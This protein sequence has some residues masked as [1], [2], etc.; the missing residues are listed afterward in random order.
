MSD[1][2]SYTCGQEAMRAE[3]KTEEHRCLYVNKKKRVEFTKIVV[4]KPFREKQKLNENKIHVFARKVSQ[5]GDRTD[6]NSPS[7]SLMIQ[8]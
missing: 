4:L 7:F 2:L 1:I 3:E 6:G 8:S 5:D